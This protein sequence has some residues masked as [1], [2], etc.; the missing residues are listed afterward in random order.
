MG[1][2]VH[3][4]STAVHIMLQPAI[5]M[6]E[7]VRETKRCASRNARISP[8]VTVQFLNGWLSMLPDM[9]TCS[10]SESSHSCG[11]QQRI[12]GIWT[13]L[14]VGLYWFTRGCAIL[15]AIVF[16]FKTFVG[17]KPWRPAL[18]GG[19][20][21]PVDPAHE[22]RASPTHAGGT[23]SMR[24]HCGG[25]VGGWIKGRDGGTVDGEMFPGE[26]SILSTAGTTG[27][28]R[29]S[30]NAL[31]TDKQ[32]YFISRLWYNIKGVS[33]WGD[34]RHHHHQT[35]VGE[36]LPKMSVMYSW[37]QVWGPWALRDFACFLP[38]GACGAERRRGKGIRWG[39]PEGLRWLGGW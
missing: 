36:V 19:C 11:T 35:C 25:R 24:V 12:W 15:K 6:M 2:F 5:E 23:W 39:E 4:M 34:R 26:A 31:C 28:L 9:V 14:P 37:C 27:G 32:R 21:T 30:Q 7:S 38:S 29:T 22:L 17:T 10:N 20:G 18:P 8:S 13:E 16:A 3:P 33:K 1:N